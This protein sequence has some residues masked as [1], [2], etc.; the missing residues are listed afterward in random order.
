MFSYS[1]ALWGQDKRV[2][3]PLVTLICGHWAILLQGEWVNV[4]YL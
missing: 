2:V 1:M 4:Q 3:V